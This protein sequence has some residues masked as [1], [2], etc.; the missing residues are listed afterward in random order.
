MTCFKNF[1]HYLFFF[2]SLLTFQNLFSQDSPSKAPDQKS[3]RF[4]VEP[5]MMF[6][7]MSGSTG[8]EAF[9]LVEVDASAFG[10]FQ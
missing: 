9:P 1:S 7:N 3:W 6:P 8:V 2:F 10:H 4:K 5:Y